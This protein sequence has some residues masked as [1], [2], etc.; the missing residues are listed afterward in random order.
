[1]PEIMVDPSSRNI[2]P[3]V[4]II[5]IRLLKK[6][7]TPLIQLVTTRSWNQIQK[8]MPFDSE[9]LTRSQYNFIYIKKKL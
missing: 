3:N 8:I 5:Q 9:Q 6:A 4:L 2:K 1:M 7:E